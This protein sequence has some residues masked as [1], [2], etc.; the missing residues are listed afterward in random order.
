MPLDASCGHPHVAAGSPRHVARLA[1][2]LV[3]VLG[4]HRARVKSGF[5]L[6]HFVGV[7]EPLAAA[8]LV[9]LLWLPLFLA[10]P[11]P[12]QDLWRGL[13]A[14]LLSVLWLRSDGE[15][16]VREHLV[17]AHLFFRTIFWNFIVGL[18]LCWWLRPHSKK[19]QAMGQNPRLFKPADVSRYPT[20]FLWTVPQLF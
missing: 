4:S 19:V 20:E 15:H 18:Y 6:L 14:E 11:R 16:F 8:G 5:E 10:L 3:A 7:H 13:F 9:A 1:S 17:R 12:C 2:V